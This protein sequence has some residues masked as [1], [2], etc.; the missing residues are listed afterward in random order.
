MEIN[1]MALRECRATLEDLE[2]TLVSTLARAEADSVAPGLIY[3]LQ[4]VGRL[5]ERLRYLLPQIKQA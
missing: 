5:A 4:G 3:D 1:E 2:K